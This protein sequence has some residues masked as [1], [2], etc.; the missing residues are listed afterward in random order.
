MSWDDTLMNKLCLKI[1]YIWEADEN[2]P[3][4]GENVRCIS[5][6]LDIV[7]DMH[8]QSIAYLIKCVGTDMGKQWISNYWSWKCLSGGI[9][10]PLYATEAVL[11]LN[12]PSVFH[13]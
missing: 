5:A 7:D 1:Q 4:A 13:V 9:K 6:S 3:A 10:N 8:L 12:Y 2:C 11:D